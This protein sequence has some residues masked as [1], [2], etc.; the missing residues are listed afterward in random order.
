MKKDEELE[1]TLKEIFTITTYRNNVLIMMIVW[2]FSSFAF[3]MVPYY[4]TH[5]KADIYY[6]SLSTESAEFLGCIASMVITKYM[7]LKRAVFMCCILIASGSFA[8]LFIATSMSDPEKH[9]QMGKLEQ[10]FNVG[11]ILVT[12]FGIVCVFDIAYCVNA[13]LFPTIFLSTAYGCCNVLGRLITISSPVVA[14]IK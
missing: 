1:G 12:N 2:S 10:Y 14:N 9:D 8:M 3:F 11:L 7:V 4:L 6:L 13:E 5:V